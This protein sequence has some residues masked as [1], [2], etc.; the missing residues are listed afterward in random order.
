MIEY[1][2]GLFDGE[3]SLHCKVRHRGQKGRGSLDL[4]LS[5]YN[6]DEN[7]M[8]W[9]VSNFGGNYCIAVKKGKSMGAGKYS[10][11]CDVYAWTL[12]E[13]SKVLIILQQIEPFCIVK[14]Q[15]IIDAMETIKSW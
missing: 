14:H 10:A 6:I 12:Y 1:F 5:I 11:S 8:Q 15:K 2:A 13:R 9:L 4:R 7:L 3:G